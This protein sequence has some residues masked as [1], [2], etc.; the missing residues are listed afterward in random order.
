MVMAYNRRKHEPIPTTHIHLKLLFKLLSA[1][2]LNGLS[3]VQS[4][5]GVFEVLIL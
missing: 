2:H 3:S 5:N 1:W 4:M